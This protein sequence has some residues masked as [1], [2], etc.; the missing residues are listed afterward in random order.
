MQGPVQSPLLDIVALGTKHVAKVRKRRAY[1]SLV[2]FLNAGG[3]MQPL[4]L[5]GFRISYSR[6]FF[7]L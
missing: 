2:S 6:S 7:E 1:R 3:I 5:R 4:R